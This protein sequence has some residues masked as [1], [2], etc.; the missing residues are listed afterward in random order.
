MDTVPQL[1]RVSLILLIGLV[2]AGSVVPASGQVLINTG[3]EVRLGQNVARELEAR[4]GIWQDPVQGA[5]VA[6]IG[7]RLGVVS[8]RTDIAY[9]FKILADSTVNALALPG[10]FIYVFRGL[11]PLMH[12]DD[13]LAFVLAH[14]VVHAAR[15]HGVQRLEGSLLL[16]LI[17]GVLTREKP[18]L[19]ASAN[20][21]RLLL[22][23]G[24]S[25]QQELEADRLAVVYM[26]R[27]GFRPAA[28]LEVMQQFMALQKQ[29]DG[30]LDRLFA[31]HPM[32][33][34]RREAASCA[35]RAVAE[36]AA[37]GRGPSA[38]VC[39]PP[40]AQPT[41]NERRESRP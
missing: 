4:Y 31:T 12:T 11:L 1:K 25:R 30:L 24:Y 14:E 17:V 36:A 2:V 5:R 34:E 20:V 37:A 41:E 15:R 6:Q 27:A 29:R 38:D 32:W 40:P 3:L 10:G 21:V 26:A 8:D 16:G 23:R 9:T 28:A 33:T 35:I 13:Q 19:D 22:E 18:D 7:Q 39:A